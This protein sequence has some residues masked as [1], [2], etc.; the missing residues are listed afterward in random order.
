V[1]KDN[2][3]SVY[4]DVEPLL[5]PRSITIV[6]ASER[7]GSWSERIFRNLR[8]YGYPGKIH[9]VNPRHRELYGAPCF[10]SVS[11]VDGEVDQMVVIV[12]ARHVP[13]AM[14][15][16]GARGCRSAVVFSGGFSETATAEGLEAERAMTAAADRHNILICGPN[17]LGNVSTRER[18]MTLAE[19]GVELFRE[20]GLALVSQSSGLMGG[21]ARYAHSRAIGLSYAIACGSEA[22]VDAADYLNFLVDDESTRV[23]GL[24]V[25]AI[26][27]PAAF[28]AACERARAARKPLLVLKIGRSKGGQT[29]ALSHTGALAGTYEA[30]KAFSRRY[31]LIEVRGFD[32]MVDPAEIFLRNPFPTAPGVAALALSGGGRG[33]IY[34]LAEDLG[35]DFPALSHKAQ[36]ELEKLL[37]VGAGIGNPLDLGAAGASDPAMQLKCFELLAGE[38]EIGLVALQGDLPQGPEFAGRAEGLKRIIDRAR[39]IGK[40]VVFFSRAS[41]PVS[42]YGACFRDACGAPFLQEIGKTFQAIGHVMDYRNA[43]QRER[44]EPERARSA[45]S[46]DLAAGL[47]LPEKEAFALL[48]SEGLTIARYEICASLES[49]ERAAQVIG[50]PVALKSSVAGLTHKSEIGGVILGVRSPEEL[51]QAF[52][53]LEK[54]SARAGIA[55]PSILVQEMV[56]ALVE[57]FVAGRNDPEFGPLVLF[58][59]GGIFVE[60]LGHHAAR[61]APVQVSE[62]EA[63]LEQSGVNKALRRL[64]MGDPS[65]RA[66]IL[67]ALLR[68]S[69]L[70]AG[71][72]E[73]DTIEINPLIY[74]GEEQSCVAVDVVAVRRG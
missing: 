23:V 56:Q 10:P 69:R 46:P 3:Q 64:G 17:C 40:P 67:D 9:L 19:Y 38:S 11:E 30:F 44:H 41:H 68:F 4:R 50:Y 53:S 35:I 61:L 36:F 57:L 22:N 1:D 51:A 6:G 49:A 25:E 31:N 66:P 65:M 32:E 7:T 34:D 60:A 8:S 16:G 47:C 58:G 59:L 27:R 12:P 74:R 73:I 18:L 52:R 72:T 26:R 24:V 5:R 43:L 70:I 33:Y 15:E 14:E 54:R 37:G 71:R 42:E 13:A 39:E 63:M 21:I 48:K 29:A 62:S 20:G 2:G 28:A 55:E 45:P